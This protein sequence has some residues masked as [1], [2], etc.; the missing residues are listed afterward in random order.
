MRRVV[1]IGLLLAA[2]CSRGPEPVST[3]A[4]EAGSVTSTASTTTA[5]P[6]STTTTASPISPVST[7]TTSLPPL[8]GID[9]EVVATGLADPLFATAPPGD[10]RL[11]VVEQAGRVWMFDGD[12]R[13]LFLDIRDVVNRKGN[14]RGLLGMAFHPNYPDDPRVFVDYTGSGGKT[15][16]A[17]Y[18]L[19]GEVLDP[20][21]ATVLLEIPQPAAN[22]NGGMVA[23]GPDGYLYVA[24]GDGGAAGDKFG[25]GQRP[26][27]L[28]A[29]LLRLDVTPEDG[30]VIPSENPFVD[31]GGAPEVWAYG[32]RNPWRFAFDDG[33]VYI[34]DVG[35]EKYEEV[36]VAPVG[37]AGL[38]Y[39][40]PITEGVHCFKPAKGCDTEG[41]TLPV[42]EYDHSQGCSITGGYVY[43]GAAIPELDGAYFYSDFCSGW[44]RS[45]RYEDGMATDEQQWADS[46]GN[47]TSFGLDGDGELLVVTRGGTIYRVVPVR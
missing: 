2:A 7:T 16:V 6:V 39:G 37:G 28:L 14:E 23:F 43:R 36:D 24:M 25:N 10:P 34:A 22:H 30:Y 32:L 5:S 33:L 46:I 40:W 20:A 29:A 31:G 9:F 27:T 41:L 45:F 11:F 38:N 3:T 21:S 42:L 35:Q 47:V 18:R 26:D 13:T 4:P 1:I 17:S 19:A 12:E 15:V 44:I 8:Q